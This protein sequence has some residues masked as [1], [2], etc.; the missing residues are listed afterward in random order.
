MLQHDPPVVRSASINLV[1]LGCSRLPVDKIA[2]RYGIGSGGQLAKLFRKYLATTPTDHRMREEAPPGGILMCA[3]RGSRGQGLRDGWIVQRAKPIA[4]MIASALINGKTIPSETLAI[5]D[6][7]LIEED[8]ALGR[9]FGFGGKLV[10]KPII[11]R[12]RRI[13]AG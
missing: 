6:V 1:V 9:R 5:D 3:Q 11:D 7:A 10:D 2:R 13:E 4:M 8:V 12:A